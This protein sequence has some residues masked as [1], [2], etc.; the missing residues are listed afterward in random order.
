MTV[1]KLIVL[2]LAAMPCVAQLQEV[3]MRTDGLNCASCAL[4]LPRALMK[5]KGVEK[6]VFQ[7]GV[8]ELKLAAKNDVSLDRVRDELKRVGYTP[9]EAQVRV[10]G[11]LRKNEKD[12]YRE[13][14]GQERLFG[15][16]L[17]L[18]PGLPGRLMDVEGIVS[19]KR[20]NALETMAV[21]SLTPVE[22]AAKP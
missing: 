21:R 18:E 5:I 8:V 16:E 12:W 4:S 10:R 19:P 13:V 7:Q 11:R 9:L 22:E 6:A 14:E 1:M 15:V 3:S 20:P 2:V 17:A